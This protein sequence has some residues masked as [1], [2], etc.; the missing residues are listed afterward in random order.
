MAGGA[1][2]VK[3]EAGITRS[4]QKVTFIS[5]T[6]YL[7]EGQNYLPSPKCLCA[8]PNM[9]FVEKLATKKRPLYPL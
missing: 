5:D 8:K 1:A 2:R 9:V 7:K 3:L 4:Y 6:T